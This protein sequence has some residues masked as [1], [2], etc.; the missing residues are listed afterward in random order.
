MTKTAARSAP[1]PARWSWPLCATPRSVYSDW[2]AIPTSPPPDLGEPEA[3]D[4]LLDA[5]TAHPAERHV[6][7][8][9]RRRRR[10]GAPQLAAS[11]RT[12]EQGRLTTAARLLERSP[13]CT[14]IEAMPSAD[15]PTGLVGGRPGVALP[16]T[17]SAGSPAAMPRCAGDC[18]LL[19]DEL[20]HGVF[21]PVRAL[22]FRFSATDRRAV[23]RCAGCETTDTIASR[24][25]MWTWPNWRRCGF[26]DHRG[27]PDR[28]P[29]PGRA[30]T[31]PPAGPAVRLSRRVA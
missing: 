23:R 10:H 3:A 22:S 20:A 28:A 14:A 1:A 5:A 6:S 26:T 19:R 30:R 9:G 13:D 11:C 2:P 16:C 29:H 12:G 8:S 4:T 18:A 21:T 7:R 17:T 31:T 27:I 24:V 15:Q 25:G